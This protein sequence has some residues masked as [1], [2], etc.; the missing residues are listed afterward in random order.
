VRQFLLANIRNDLAY[1]HWVA[2]G[3]PADDQVDVEYAQQMLP[4]LLPLFCES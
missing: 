1:Y 4:D 2:K 3:K